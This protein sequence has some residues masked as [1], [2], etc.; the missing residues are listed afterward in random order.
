MQ[1]LLW[2][3]DLAPSQAALK[4]NSVRLGFMLPGWTGGLEDRGSGGQV[5][6]RHWGSGGLMDRWTGGWGTGGLGSPADQGDS[7]TGGQWTR[8]LGSRLVFQTNHWLLE[9]IVLFQVLRFE[10]LCFCNLCWL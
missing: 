2:F 6:R 9:F 10:F 4:L 1:V 5:D 3:E 7:G 8:G